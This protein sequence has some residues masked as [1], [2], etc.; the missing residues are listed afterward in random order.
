MKRADFVQNF[1][2]VERDLLFERIAS[3][4]DFPL[5]PFKIQMHAQTVRDLLG[6]GPIYDLMG[7][8]IKDAQLWEKQIREGNLRVD[9]A[10]KTVAVF[11]VG[12]H[13]FL[14]RPPEKKR[15]THWEKARKVYQQSGV[16]L[17]STQ[18]WKKC[19]KEMTAAGIKRESFIRTF[20]TKVKNW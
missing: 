18:L 14:Q 13:K 19:E 5:T 4:R 2:R 6:R 16:K 10:I 3:E 9:T 17:N 11:L 1:Q 7:Q 20:K 12:I 8:V 15:T